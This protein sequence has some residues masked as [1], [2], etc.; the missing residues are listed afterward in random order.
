MS[1]AGYVLSRREL[2]GG[3]GPITNTGC[4][5]HDGLN[6]MSGTRVPGCPFTPSHLGHEC[7]PHTAR[8]HHNPK[9]QRP[10]PITA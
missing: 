6:V 5:V 2:P 9:G 8:T 1:R 3:A 4:P 7:A 10:N